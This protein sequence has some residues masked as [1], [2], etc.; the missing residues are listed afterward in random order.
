MRG[1][2]KRKKTFILA[3]LIV[4]F[5]FLSACRG[6]GDSGSDGNFSQGETSV[7]ESIVAAESFAGMDSFA[8]GT[9]SSVM[10]ESFP[11]TESLAV[12][13]ES[14]P[15]MD[16]YVTLTIHAEGKEQGR[17][18]LE[19]AKGKLEGL[20]RLWSVTDEESELY[21]INHSDGAPVT[22]S[23]ETREILSFA[24]DEAAETDG[25]LDPTI[26]PVLAAWGF[27]TGENR[28]PPPEEGLSQP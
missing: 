27:T 3:A 23:P 10:A 7:T 6:G 5:L 9:E 12:V 8:A 19:E 2:M 20:E 4:I 13:T 28:I 21:Q 18:I 26:Y 16:T 22:V 24:L 11:M 17:E 25:A 14:F 15:V 1:Y